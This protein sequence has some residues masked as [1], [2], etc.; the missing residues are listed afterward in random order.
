MHGLPDEFAPRRLLK[1]LGLI[2]GLL[3]A[4]VLA[5]LLAPGLGEVQRR[6]GDAD[7]GWLLLAVVLEALSCALLRA[8]VP[9]GLLP[10]DVAPHEQRDRA[11][12]AGGRL[13]RADQ[14]RQRARARR[15]DPASRGHA[16]RE[17]RAPQRRL[18]RD[19]ERG[20]LRR[21]RARRRA[22]GGRPARSAAVVAAD[23]AAGRALRRL[24][25]GRGGALAPRSRR[26]SGQGRAVA[27]PRRPRDPRRGRHRHR[28]GDR[29]AAPPRPAAAGGRDRLLGVRQRRACGR[30]SRPSAPTSR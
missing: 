18:P 30:R 26:R 20:Q 17:D 25:G 11:G 22:D 1:R 5:A 29:V 3:A 24:P 15:L 7:A 2:A 4:L 14:R 8:H 13:A 27:A 10:A 19:Q 16:G 23:R 6:L 28:G 9:T 21:R 12:R